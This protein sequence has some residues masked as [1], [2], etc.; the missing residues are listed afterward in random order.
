ML[1]LLLR[2]RVC[3]TLRRVH[4]TSLPLLWSGRGRRMVDLLAAHLTA[5]AGIARINA[6]LVPLENGTTRE[7]RSR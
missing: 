2:L 7:L 5:P 6:S 1:P 4:R 3:L